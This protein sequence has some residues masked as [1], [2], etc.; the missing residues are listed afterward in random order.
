MNVLRYRVEFCAD[1]PSTS[2]VIDQLRA[3]AF[4][5]RSEES[6][7]ASSFATNW[8]FCSISSVLEVDF[9]GVEDIACGEY[10]LF[11]LRRERRRLPATL[12]KA[13]LKLRIAAWLQEHNR[14]RCPATVKAE[15]KDAL[16]IQMLSRSLPES[17]SWGACWSPERRE[18]ILER[19]A[20]DVQL[21]F[22]KAFFEAFGLR[23]YRVEV[24][25]T[26]ADSLLRGQ[27]LVS[28]GQEYGN[29]EPLYKEDFS[30]TDPHETTDEPTPVVT[31]LA[32]EFKLWLWWRMSTARDSEIDLGDDLGIIT[33][34]GGS[35]VVLK[36]ISQGESVTV[37][38][39]APLS[40]PE[41]L[42][43][44]FEG[45][46]PVELPVMWRRDDR[47]FSLSL[48]GEHL[49]MCGLQLPQVVKGDGE[50]AMLDRMF[51][52]EE[53]CMILKALFNLFAE[54][55]VQGWVSSTGD[56]R[57]IRAWIAEQSG[58]DRFAEE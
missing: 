2:L 21:M 40:D 33:I 42:Q 36:D 25:D 51:L 17:K 38:A 57:A 30:K 47:E 27:L 19:C 48:R 5:P 9:P 58:D 7:I 54:R 34:W 39:T 37:V 22:Q 45:K 55:R 13:H 4:R 28:R 11:A 18:L 3:Y 35:R 44:L 50:E 26:V 56:G 53:V 41:A 14:S 8:G 46:L 6:E 24:L 15:I 32:A 43:A 1:L 49:D 23:L 29:G 31:H 20:E 52:F 10:L 16:Q 12:F